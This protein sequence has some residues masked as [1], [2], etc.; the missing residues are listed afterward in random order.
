MHFDLDHRSASLSAGEF[1]DFTLSPRESKGGPSGLWRAQLGSHWHR[2]L[3][4][5]VTAQDSTARFEVPIQGKLQANGWTLSFNGR[6]DQLLD[7]DELLSIREIKTV[8]RTLPADE[9][10]LRAEYASY[11]LQLACYA[12]LLKMA[13]GGDAKSGKAEQGLAAEL[14]FV[15]ADSGLSQSVALSASDEGAFRAQLERV[16]GFFQQRWLARERLRQLRIRA[17][18]A[19]F[20][21][22]QEQAL[23]SLQTALTQGNRA[24]LF[25]APTGFGKTGIMLE[26]ALNQMREG[27]FERLLYLTSKATGQ[28]QV[29]QTLNSMCARQEPPSDVKIPVSDEKIAIGIWLVRPKSEHCINDHFHCVRDACAYMRDIP[30]RWEKSGVSQIFLNPDSPRDIESLR[31]AG[32]VASLC[33]YEITRAALPFS[34]V[35]IGDINYVFS[36]SARGVFME[37][38]GFNPNRSLLI[39]DEA[40]NLPARVADAYSHRFSVEDARRIVD[41]LQIIRAPHSLVQ[42]LEHWEHFLR[43]LPQH[44]TLPLIDEDD[45]R[46]LLESAAKLIT[47]TPLDYATLGSGNSE[48]LWQIPSL[49]EQL[50]TQAVLARHWW[51]PLAGVL[52]ITCT[53]A[54][55]A[56]GEALREFG[57][58]ILSSATFGPQDAFAEAIGLVEPLP[59]LKPATIASLAT[60]NLLPKP[61]AITECPDSETVPGKLGKLTKRQTRKLFK[62]VTS[63]A[64]LLRTEETRSLAAITSVR[65]DAPWREG[66]YDIAVDLRVD[67][68]FQHRDRYYATTAATLLAWHAA[69]GSSAQPCAAF[70]PSYA[71]A[72]AILGELSSIDRLLRASLQPKG[73]DHAS[74]MEWLNQA[75]SGADVLMLVLG[76]SFA[77]GIDLLGGRVSRAMLVGPALPEVNPIQHARMAALAKLGREASFR[78][79][80]QIPGMQKVNQALGRLVRAPGQKA[81]I[82]LHCRRFAEPSYDGLLA[83][84]YRNGQRLSTDAELL[85]W[86]TH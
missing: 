26:A 54:A 21:E 49:V 23:H 64:E 74:Q 2:L 25:E 18:F 33:P 44:G 24:L 31:N 11:F 48:M 50:R 17:P 86:F 15:E 14:V 63:G 68:T 57:G 16:T 69:C 55:P 60:Q 3:Q 7:R 83:P 70:F 67:T 46:H 75:L 10:E 19:L 32:R 43:H 5:R 78:R 42:T 4:E 8:L 20:R 1:A 22:G 9:S 61:A 39:V 73:V 28:L 36:P 82:L 41:A 66:A 65:A 30:A 35:W 76:S 72:E 45:A 34:D 62:Q 29:V 52:S 47:T 77:E 6:I 71:Y 13:R 81:R 80:Y 53:D 12:T 40:H 58:I 85:T 27:H 56:I 37:Q 59:E 84:E 51:S 38:P 79:V